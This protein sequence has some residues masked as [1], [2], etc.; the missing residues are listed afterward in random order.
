MFISVAQFRPE[1]VKKTVHRWH[2]LFA[3]QSPL[4]EAH[5]ALAYIF[6]QAHAV[7]LEALSLALG[8]LDASSP[9]PKLLLVGSCRNSDDEERV[10]ELRE[11]CGRLG[12]DRDVEFHVDVTYRFASSSPSFAIL[13]L[14]SIFSSNCSN[15]WG[16]LEK[17]MP[18][19]RSGD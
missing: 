5:V 4:M 8:R 9:R 2:S 1:K 11:L 13:C 16:S 7:Q 10:K 12:I 17:L 14:L 6:N 18:K 15:R 3:L 19:L